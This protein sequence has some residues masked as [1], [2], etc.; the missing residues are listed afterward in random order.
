MIQWPVK[1]VRCGTFSPKKMIVV[2]AV[3]Y[4]DIR[5]WSYKM[6]GGTTNL[7]NHLIHKHP[8]VTGEMDSSPSST[9]KHTKKV[10]FVCTSPAKKLK[11]AYEQCTSSSF[12]VS[13]TTETDI[14]DVDKSEQRLINYHETVQ[15]SS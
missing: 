13:E 14:E 4:V 2:L 10:T 3:V 8:L 9:K 1:E 11:T 7:R 6:G 5:E 12:N 15:V